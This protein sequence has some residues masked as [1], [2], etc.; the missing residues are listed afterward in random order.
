MDKPYAP[1]PMGGIPHPPPPSVRDWTPNSSTRGVSISTHRRRT[2]PWLEVSPHDVRQPHLD[3]LF[4]VH[5]RQPEIAIKRPPPPH[6][7]IPHP[8]SPPLM[9]SSFATALNE[10]YNDTTP[11][12]APPGRGA[13]ERVSSR[14]LYIICM[15]THFPTSQR[16]DE[17][18]DAWDD[19][20]DGG[21]GG[22]VTNSLEQTRTLLPPPPKHHRGDPKP[23]HAR[24]CSTVLTFW[25]RRSRAY[26]VV[27]AMLRRRRRERWARWSGQPMLL[28][29]LARR[30]LGRARV[31]P[32]HL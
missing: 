3:L 9:Y 11:P 5:I 31:P 24:P 29:G 32:S 18:V 10:W 22:A 16:V 6:P 13:R 14:N 21:V 28:S 30:P 27:A 4:V 20:R 26:A 2:L 7:Q 15:D 19:H 25:R 12:R 17:A 8:A 1:P 23:P